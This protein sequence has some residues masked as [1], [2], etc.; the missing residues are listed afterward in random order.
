MNTYSVSFNEK[1][2]IFSDTDNPWRFKTDDKKDYD[3]KISLVKT[4]ESDFCK[5]F[6][7]KN[8]ENT[9]SGKRI[10]ISDGKNACL[11]IDMVKSEKDICIYSDFTISNEDL[12]ASCNVADKSKLVIRN[13][14]CG[15]KHFRLESILDG[16]SVLDKSG[17]MMPVSI[18]SNGDISYSMYEGLY[19]FGKEHFLCFGFA[20]DTLGEI[21]YWHLNKTEN[22]YLINHSKTEN[23]IEIVK[24]GENLKLFSSGDNKLL[25]EIQL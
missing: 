18:S 4:T 24:D 19:S 12:S 21:I 15:V 6:E 1:N 25:A 11:I 7:Y 8:S 2:V 16:E 23:G 14:D 22:G 13:S 20:L 17:L 3:A 9:F 5:V 10:C